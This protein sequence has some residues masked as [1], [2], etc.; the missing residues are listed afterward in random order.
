MTIERIA[1][2]F[3]VASGASDAT[4]LI[5]VFHRWIQDNA[6]QG[7]PLDVA[8][9][10]HVPNGPGVILIGHDA[11]WGL[12]SHEGPLG[13]IYNH[14]RNLQGG[15]DADRIAFALRQLIHAARLLEEDPAF[16]VTFDSS[17]L[18]ITFNDRLNQPNTP[19]GFAAVSAAVEAAVAEVFGAEVS[20]MVERDEQDPRYRL[21][22]HVGLSP[23][24]SLSTLAVEA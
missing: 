14:K 21:T 9:Y 2:K 23:V 7:V 1:V 13:L 24:P 12:D 10:R 18:R 6:V 19:E 15:S 22:V 5:P 16:A 4:A 17:R 8:D 20:L 3:P 11:D